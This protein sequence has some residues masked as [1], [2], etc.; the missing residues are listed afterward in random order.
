MTPR[1]YLGLA[2]AGILAASVAARVFLF[3][4]EAPEQRS[5]SSS[6]IAPTGLVPG[7]HP[8][9]EERIEEGEKKAGKAMPFISEAAFFGVIGFA[10]GYASRKIVKLGLI[11]LALLFVA[12]QSLS[13][14]G[15]IQVDWQRGL[16]LLN[17]FVLNI[18]EGQSAG[19]IL[20]N[21]IPTAATLMAGYLIG[22]RKG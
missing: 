12:V 10:V 8:D 18:Q 16:D 21:R 5:S 19:E 2:L 14:A 20:K 22:F 6:A 7:D 15:V 11:L 3:D 17:R 9:V 4:P 13:Y 1:A